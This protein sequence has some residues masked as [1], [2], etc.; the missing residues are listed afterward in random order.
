MSMAQKVL[1]GVTGGVAAYK[2]CELVRALVDFGC[3]VDVVVTDAAEHFAPVGALRAI[4]NGQLHSSLYED[5]D[6]S[7]HTS[8]AREADLL[9]CYPATADFIAKI[10]NGHADDLLS[11]LF[12]ASNGPKM[13]APAMHTEMWNAPATRRNVET[14]KRDGCQV[15]GPTVGRLAGG[16][17]GAGRL[18]SPEV[19]GFAVRSTLGLGP[20]L[21]Q[22]LKGCRIVVT[23][24][25]T[26]EALDPVRYIGNRSSGKQGAAIAAVAAFGGAEVKLIT[27]VGS[28]LVD[29][30]GEGLCTVLRVESAGEMAAAVADV[31]ERTDILIMAAAVADYAPRTRE[32]HKIKRD[33]RS[34]LSVSL[35]ATEDVL[36]GAALRRK[37]RGSSLPVLVG[38]AAESTDLET[39]VLHKL[40]AKG[41]D[42]VVG[43][44][45]AG[46]DPVFGADENQVVIVNRLGES[47]HYARAP[48]DTVAHYVLGAAAQILREVGRL[49]AD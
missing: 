8:L 47:Q 4:I 7:P 9:L 17:A 27:T 33:G 31:E 49:S 30:L 46:G 32:V 29:G 14:V 40:R 19:M 12:L 28:S 37:S 45:V 23:A 36:R 22:Q 24:G 39:A 48:K 20:S 25:G 1:V 6:P 11:T 41:V 35:V 42:V 44:L 15:I 21:S 38:F 43:N 16:D 5:A 34:E 13:I 18:V 10:A 3:E 26:R 2:A